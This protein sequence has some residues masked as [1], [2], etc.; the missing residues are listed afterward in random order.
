MDI[1]KHS[2]W[3]RLNG[4]VWVVL[5]NT[6]AT[7]KFKAISDYIPKSLVGVIDI[8][9]KKVEYNDILQES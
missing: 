3:V 7:S 9:G 4:S 8:S 1:T 6:S 2:K 5:S